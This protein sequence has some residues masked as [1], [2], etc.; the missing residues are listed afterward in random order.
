MWHLSYVMVILYKYK[1][2][3]V[4]I[5]W[6]VYICLDLCDLEGFHLDGACEVYLVRRCVLCV[7][8]GGGGGTWA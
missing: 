4:Y 1:F 5:A 3:A 2:V 7:C 6:S 8:G